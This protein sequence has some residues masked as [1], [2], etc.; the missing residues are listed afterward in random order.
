ME[1]VD[2]WLS[3]I[4]TC[5]LCRK[6][7][8][9]TGVTPIPGDLDTNELLE[10]DTLDNFI[11]DTVRSRSV[12]MTIDSRLLVEDSIEMWISASVNYRIADNDMVRF[13]NVV[14]HVFPHEADIVL[15][16]FSVYQSLNESFVREYIHLF[17]IPNIVTFQTHLDDYF[18]LELQVEHLLEN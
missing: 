3:R 4:P 17:D 1:C 9:I 6:P 16:N 10:Y 12:L 11:Q 5:P 2:A 14:R 15:F 7:I 8:D 13:V 18:L